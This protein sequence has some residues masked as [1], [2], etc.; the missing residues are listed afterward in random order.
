M[1]SLTSLAKK[2]G[3]ADGESEDDYQCVQKVRDWL[4]TTTKPF[5]LIFDNVDNVELLN[6]IWPA[7]SRGSIIITTR[8]PSQAAKRATTILALESFSGATGRSILQSLTGM[9]PA[10]VDD[11]A[12]ADEIC[13]LVGGLPLAMVQISGFIRDRGY[14]Y[15]EFLKIFERSA[16]KV[17]K[18]SEI[19]IDYDRTLLATWDISLQRLSAEA[20]TLQNLL[21][22]FDPDLIPERLI[23][24]TKAEIDDERLE[25][26][27]DDFE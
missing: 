5:L 7:S 15:V 26:L 10:D 25:F 17:L 8:S 14:S 11:A 1:Q 23:K 20:T 6:Q 27:F 24:D 2:L 21:V 16:E 18:K 4:N 9:P 22:F 13:R 12:A 19:P 3:L